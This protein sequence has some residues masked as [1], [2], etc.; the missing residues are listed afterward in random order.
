M[1]F[2]VKLEARLLVQRAEKAFKYG[3]RC[4]AGLITAS[5]NFD[6]FTRYAQEF[7][8]FLPAGWEMGY[9]TTPVIGGNPF[10]TQHKE[11]YVI[12]FYDPARCSFTS[13]NS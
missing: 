8:E 6:E 11:A 3:E 7:R 12:Q 9:T 5:K 13:S 10:R 2:M 1:S 4:S